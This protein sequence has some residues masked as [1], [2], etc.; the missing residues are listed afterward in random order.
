MIIHTA[1]LAT[2]LSEVSRVR[3]VPTL[4]SSPSP[5]PGRRSSPRASYSAQRAFRSLG[6]F[7]DGLSQ[8]L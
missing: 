2:R 4:H 1:V 5:V 8:N 3:R 7:A 6:S